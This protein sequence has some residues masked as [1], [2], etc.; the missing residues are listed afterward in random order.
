MKAKLQRIGTHNI[1]DVSILE[2][3]HPVSLYLLPGTI[4]VPVFLSLV[5]HNE[6][7]EG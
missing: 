1:K 2:C 7:E 5:A 3:L 6:G 4:L